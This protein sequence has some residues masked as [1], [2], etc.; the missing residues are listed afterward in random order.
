MSGGYGRFWIK[1]EVLQQFSRLIILHHSND[2][3]SLFAPGFDVSVSFGSLFQRIASTYDR[4]YL[5]C[6]DKLFEVG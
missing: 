4:F 2:D 5:P 1:A 3:I 6:L